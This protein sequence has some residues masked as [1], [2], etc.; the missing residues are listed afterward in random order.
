MKKIISLPLVIAIGLMITAASC[1]TTN[2]RANNGSFSN[3]IREHNCPRCN[4]SGRDN[5]TDRYG[6][7]IRQTCGLCSGTGK[8]H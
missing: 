4:G 5:V 2:P 6:N 1:S 8:V 7:T 3:S